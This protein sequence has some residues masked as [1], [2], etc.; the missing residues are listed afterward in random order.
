MQSGHKFTPGEVDAKVGD[1]IEWRFYPVEHWVIRG[2]FDYPCV[3]Y[4]YIGTDRKSFDSGAQTVQAITDDVSAPS[5]ERR[6]Q[7]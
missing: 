2:D 3:P 5:A 7:D 4:D 1:I 6:E